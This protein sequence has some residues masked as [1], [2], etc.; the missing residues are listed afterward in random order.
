[1][2]RESE[3]HDTFAQIAAQE[4]VY[5][6]DDLI[7]PQ[8]QELPT[9]ELPITTDGQPISIEPLERIHTAEA[10]QAELESMR[11]KYAPFM[12]TH[13][14]ELAK[15][16]SSR[17]IDTFDWRIQTSSDKSDFP[18]VL[19]GSGSWEKVSIPHYGGP[20]GRTSTYYRTSIAI[21]AEELATGAAFV[22]FKGVD[23]KA[24][25]FI[26]G[27]FL[28]SHEGFFAPF[29]FEFSE[30]ARE[31]EN[32][33]LVQV[34]N[35]FVCGSN[36]SWGD[37]RSGDKI[38][39]ATGVGYDDP[40]W[41]W[42]HCPPGM[43]IY[44]DVSIEFRNQAYLSD[45]FIRPLPEAGKAEIW[46]EAS[47][48]NTRSTL[49]SFEISIYGRNFKKTVVDKFLHSPSVISECGLGDDLTIARAKAAGTYQQ[50]TALELG[51]GPNQFR[52]TV[53]MEE[54]RWWS[55]E[56]P[57][58]YQAQISMLDGEGK[59]LDTAEQRF[60]MRSFSMDEESEK[61]GSL[62]LNGK[63]IRLRGANT[64]GHEQQC[65][66]K[67]DWDQLRD[68]ILLAKICNMN[69]LRLT[70]RPVQSE[71]YDY[72]D[73]LGIMTQSD[74]PT[75]GVIRRNQ[76]CE[77]LRQV[78]EM[79][80]LVRPHPCNIM[81]SYINEPV[82]NSG[83][84]PHR[85]MNREELEGFFESADKIVKNLNPDRV[86]KACDGDYDPPSPGIQDRHCYCTWYNGQGVDYG[87]LHKGYWQ[88]TKANWHYGCGEFGAE[89]LEDSGLMRRHYPDTWLPSDS[90]DE[91]T[92][93]PN[94]IK[95]AQTGRFHYFFFETQESLEQ[96]I[97]ASQTYQA[98]AMRT[99]AEAFRRDNNMVTFAVHLFIDA[100]PSGWM[101]TIMDCERRPKRAYFAYRDA[102]APLLPNLRA[103]RS[104]YFSGENIQ[105]EAWI[106]NDQSNFESD[107]QLRYSIECDGSI[108]ASGQTSAKID[109][110]AARFQGYLSAQAPETGARKTITA[111]LAIVTPDGKTLNDTTLDLEIFPAEKGGFFKATVHG[112]EDGAAN[113][114]AE[115]LGLTRTDDA[116]IIILDNYQDFADEQENI[117]E[118]VENGAR[119]ILLE[120][121]PGM[122]QLGNHAVVVKASGFNA[123]HFA[124]RRTGHRLVDQFQPHDFR[125][126][127]DPTQEYIAPFLENT[128]TCP[129]ADPILL[130]GN[131]DE[132]G[133]WTEALA[134]GELR[135]GKGSIIICQ[136]QLA[137]RTETNPPARIFADRLIDATA[138]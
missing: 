97:D 80:R 28:G 46:F 117:L 105:L 136:I 100:F 118:R 79:E 27:N 124:S 74:L 126:W 71:V 130:S 55:P 9:I 62:F 45:I 112:S 94:R 67:K 43:G 47:Q 76:Y 7:E 38:Y 56:T 73:M 49:V 53:D 51:P 63:P 110:V 119:T 11:E 72:C 90:E 66:L 103:D 101:K 10:L 40:E 84:E 61:K 64:M 1:M 68:D 108:L 29:E 19:A 123:L 59:I 30:L 107:L 35:D 96:W 22:C 25:V 65:V 26:N 69:F 77:A 39:A 6:S 129:T 58:L 88:P 92:W 109:P 33:L 128:F 102:L 86:T 135:Y 42:H 60:G 13:A 137:G 114:L 54:I 120:L 37:K 31:G 2:L 70:Q 78:E 98:E 134:A 20:L 24:R 50:P 8:P 83:N 132:N 57:W 87:R 41:G 44:Q 52:V 133:Q 4:V 23:Y 14:P 89:G 106:C 75:F 17:S 122:Y 18:A 34:D 104:R 113:R 82:V 15:R 48:C 99:M 131:T 85:H 93:S 36:A 127:Y 95:Q 91:K 116:D 115:E 12:Q 21:S 111:H 125:H 121:S 3:T 16:R 32:T 81:V 138:K 5:R